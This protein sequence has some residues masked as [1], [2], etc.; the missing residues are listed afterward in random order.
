MVRKNTV[1][2]QCTKNYK[3]ES[4]DVMEMFHAELSSHYTVSNNSDL[5]S[6][7]AGP[8]TNDV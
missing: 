4:G 7:R 2:S 3:S 6:S 8:K 1:L 5:W